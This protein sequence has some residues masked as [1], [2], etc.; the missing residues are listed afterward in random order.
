MLGIHEGDDTEYYTPVLYSL[1]GTFQVVNFNQELKQKITTIKRNGTF[2][3]GEYVSYNKGRTDEDTVWSSSDSKIATVDKNGKVTG[4]S[5]GYVVITATNEG[6]TDAI[7]IHVDDK[8]DD[9]EPEIPTSPNPSPSD[10]ITVKKDGND[11]VI[12]QDKT[13]TKSSSLP[14]TSQET[15]VQDDTVAQG[16]YPKTG[17]ITIVAIFGLLIIAA[18]YVIRQNFK[19]RDIK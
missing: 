13:Q 19:M 2:P 16:K 17:K 3:A 7:V 14:G 4:I 8:S 18:G 15:K 6:S 12:S 9:K 11:L 1:P 10:G 5:N